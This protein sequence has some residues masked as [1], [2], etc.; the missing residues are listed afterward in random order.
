MYFYFTGKWCQ[1]VKN[2]RA[3]CSKIYLAQTSNFMSTN[4]ILY[5]YQIATMEKMFLKSN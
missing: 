1:Q 4:V 2:A 5:T 3:H